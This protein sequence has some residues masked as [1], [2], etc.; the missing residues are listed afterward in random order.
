MRRFIIIFVNFLMSFHTLWGKTNLLN[1]EKTCVAWQAQKTLTFFLD[2][3]PLG[4]N[5]QLNEMFYKEGDQYGLLIDIPLKGFKS[6]SSTRDQYI[7]KVLNYLSQPSLYFYT[8]KM[9][10]EKWTYF[11]DASEFTLPGYLSINKNKYPLSLRVKKE[12]YKSNYYLH[13][14]VEEGFSY[15][16]LERPIQLWGLGFEV[17]EQLSLLFQYRFNSKTEVLKKITASSPL[18]NNMKNH[19]TIK[20]ENS[21]FYNLKASKLNG[22]EVDFKNYKD[23]VVMIVNIA[24]KCGYTGQLKDLQY[25]HNTYKDKGFELLAFPSNNF[26]QEPL[27]GDEI[28]KFCRLNYGVSFDITRKCHVKG[29][30]IHPVY[31]YLLENSTPKNKNIRWNFEKFIIDKKGKVVE[32][33]SS[34]VSPRGEKIVNLIEGLLK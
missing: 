34:S 10:L 21:G 2:R 5:C 6:D 15:F 28:S 27:E 19:M 3:E 22:Q 18:A 14:V 30:E 12:L 24:S 16:D 7:L 11:L 13:G 31:E 32:R 1:H 33:F 20:K 23:K 25:L 29:Q 8:E 17:K 4:Q 9:S 26:Y